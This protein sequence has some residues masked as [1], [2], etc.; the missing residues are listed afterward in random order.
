[1]KT[2]IVGYVPVLHRGYLDLLKKYGGD[3]FLLGADYVADVPRLERDIR[4]VPPE[5]LAAAFTGCG[6]VEKAVVLRKDNRHVLD[7]YDRIVMPDDLVSHGFADVYLNG[8]IVQYDSVFLRWDRAISSAELIV[9]PDRTISVDRMHQSLMS[10]A[11]DLARRSPDWWRQIGALI[12]KDGKVVL[13]AYNRPLIDESY[14]IDALGDPRSDF[15]YGER[16]DLQKNIHGESWLIAEAARLGISLD[17]TE[18][19]VT[20]F[21]C[22]VCAKLIAAAGIKRVYYAK[23]YSLLDAEYIL[24]AHGVKIVLVRM[25]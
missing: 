1:M 6:A 19:Y 8:R 9:S 15:D 20:T 22:P 18:M 11:A 23:G 12:V 4:A 17:G 21:P 2:A 16:I 13:T 14:V 3:L 25:D 7:G 5:A 24:K 10:K